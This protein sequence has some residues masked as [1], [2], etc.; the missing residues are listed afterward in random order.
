MIKD[1]PNDNARTSTKI[2]K[3]GSKPA[4]TFS[5]P[6]KFFELSVQSGLTMRGVAGANANNPRQLI[7]F[8]DSQR[9]VPEEMIEI[10]MWRVLSLELLK[11][12]PLENTPLNY[13]SLWEVK[14]HLCPTEGRKEELN[15]IFES[16]TGF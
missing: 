16:E 6:K 15:T 2:E 9:I 8:T 14:I 12:T 5:D 10:P 11:E 3:K 4:M 7:F 13:P 1:Q